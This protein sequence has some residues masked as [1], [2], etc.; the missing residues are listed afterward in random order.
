MAHLVL[1]K[2]VAI[3][4]FVAGTD[5]V[6]WEYGEENDDECIFHVADC[7][8]QIPDFSMWWMADKQ[9]LGTF[10]EYIRRK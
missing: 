7:E 10:K 9:K 2:E 4:A 3:K 5:F 6:F 1:T 8:N